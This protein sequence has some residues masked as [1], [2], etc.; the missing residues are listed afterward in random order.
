MGVKLGIRGKTDIIMNDGCLHPAY[1]K[2]FVKNRYYVN[3]AK[4]CYKNN[5]ANVLSS[6][7]FLYSHLI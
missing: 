3:P 5:T 4:V 6:N 7:T 2:T 1:K